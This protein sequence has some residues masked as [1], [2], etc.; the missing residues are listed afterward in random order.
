LGTCA[1]VTDRGVG[2]RSHRPPFIPTPKSHAGVYAEMSARPAVLPTEG[3]GGGGC[4]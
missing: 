4:L 3:H 2:Y 1:Y